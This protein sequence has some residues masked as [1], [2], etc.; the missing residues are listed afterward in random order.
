MDIAG[1]IHLLNRVGLD[2]TPLEVAE[3]VW[4]AQYASPPAGQHGASAEGPAAPAAETAAATA[5]PS[6]ARDGTGGGGDE[7]QGRRLPLH[8]PPGPGTREGQIASTA[9][10]VRVPAAA[11]LPD[12]LALMRALRPLKRRAP[13]PRQRLL[14]EGASASETA[15]AG[16]VIPV[17][18]DGDSRWLSLTLV[19]DTGP[20]MAVWDKLQA[21]LTVLFQ[22][23]GAFRDLQKWYLRTDRGTVLGVTRNARHAP[24]DLHDTAELVDPAGRRLI[25][26]LSDGACAA[27][28]SGAMAR[29][30]EQWGAH[31]PVAI[32]QPLPQQLWA[33]TGLSPVRVRLTCARAAAPNAALSFSPYQRAARWR[34]LADNG[35][36]QVPVPVLEIGQGWLR[37]WARFIA[38]APNAELDCSVAFGS[39][40]SAP[41]PSRLPDQS[42]EER[43][44]SFA[45]Q[46][47]PEA[48]RLAACLAATQLS[49]PVMRHVQAAMV[50]GAGPPHLAEV[51]LGGL[52]STRDA[53]RNPDAAED[54]RYEFAP[55]V[56]DVLLCG[57]GRTQARQVL[58]EVSRQL[59]TR[60]GRSVDEFAAVAVASPSGATAPGPASGRPFAEIAAHVLER[61]SGQF[62]T[63]PDGAD[64]S[65]G[66][67]AEEPAGTADALIRRY[68]RTGRVADIDEAVAFLRRAWPLG[69]PPGSP[70]PPPAPERARLL[71]ELALALQERFAALGE[72][73]DL[74]DAAAALHE[75]LPQT[76][77]GPLRARLHAELAAVL[78]VRY[79]QTSEPA[80]ID[81]AIEAAHAATALAGKGTAE[82]AR[83][84]GTLGSLL[85]ARAGPGGMSGDL[86]NAVKWLRSATAGPGLGDTANAKLLADLS[87]A[88]RY[89]AASPHGAAEDLDEAVA[90]MRRA[91]TLSPQRDRD[92]QRGTRESRDLAAR[93][94]G[95]GA[96]LFDRSGTG[97]ADADLRD[98]AGNYRKAAGLAPAAGEETASYLAGLGVTLR[99]LARLTESGPDLAEAVRSLREAISETPPG[100]A[101]RPRR[102]ADLAQALITRFEFYG[103]RGE[104]VEACQLLDEAVADAPPGSQERARYLMALGG[105]REQSYSVTAAIRDLASA[106][107]AYRG[108][109]LA[110]AGH[111]KRGVALGRVLM[112]LGR[113]EEAVQV[114]RDAAAGLTSELGADHPD[115]LTASLALARA[116]AAADRP[117]E[118]LATLDSLLPV[119]R[120]VLDP[121][122]PDIR[123]AREL[124]QELS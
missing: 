79:A 112:T 7:D 53:A 52:I 65:A 55:G 46:A 29:V 84:A 99:E 50:P 51:L 82:S 32:L 3:A 5:R 104:L 39:A 40:Q 45:E 44:R 37:A 107:D 18:R 75:A 42:A 22:R 94:A 118:A 1:L 96:A 47:S 56:R 100:D 78:G 24:A 64:R 119:Q 111:P 9:L 62:S 21:E 38:G 19:V 12:G 60:F 98:A 76:E 17:L 11:A 87:T 103:G 102:Q 101:A 105:A 14:D 88:L 27:W 93:H 66:P 15:R 110:A 31:G 86:D 97:G 2:V 67:V 74:D 113:T 69:R 34:R 73:Q 30:L 72:R 77:P 8:L 41:S 36:V 89:R 106:A 25:L 61:L 28:Y 13:D 120:R 54:W 71:S 70:A 43:V 10:P 6:A 49:L 108:A 16:T 121:D 123:T 58:Y 48:M 114:L 122:H 117:R 92:L 35:A 20:A 4:L 63:R 124:R 109:M 80:D 59:T 81:E 85:L 68:Q 116:L 57:L 91:I 83:Y 90:V 26:L 33:R 23:L 95:L 115:A